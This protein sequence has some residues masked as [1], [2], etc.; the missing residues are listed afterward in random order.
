VGS[1]VS[2]LYADDVEGS[3]GSL[4]PEAQAQAA[5]SIGA[6]GAIAAD[7]PPDAAAGLVATTGDAFTNAMA[8]GLF[9]A[10][11][12]AAA[13]AVVVARFLPARGRDAEAEVIVLDLQLADSDRAA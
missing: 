10:S 11:V 4:P 3:L 13:T 12:L 5:D 2:S 8:T 7:L 6:A 9:I 1:L